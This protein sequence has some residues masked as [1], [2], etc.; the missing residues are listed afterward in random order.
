M[1]AGLDAPSHHVSSGP[2]PSSLTTLAEVLRRAGYATVAVTGGGPLGSEG[3]LF[4]GFDRYGYWVGQDDYYELIYGINRVMGWLEA[5]ADRP[6]FLFFHTF[7]VSDPFR[8]RAPYASEFGVDLQDAV[9]ESVRVEPAEPKTT[10]LQQSRQK[11]VWPDGSSYEEETLSSEQRASVVSLYDSG[12]AYAD[13]AFGQLLTR[14]RELRLEHDTLVILTS[15][16]GEALGEHGCIGHEYLSEED[17]R[18]PLVFAFPR[19]LEEPRV[20]SARARSVDILPTVIDLL[21]LPSLSG[22]DGVSLVP[23]MESDS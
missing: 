6:F 5:N 7:E 16:H 1:F 18:V 13:N 15:D 4:Q 19:R 12:I 21:G 14:L 10:G 8:A 3:G 2:A 17:L 23:L 9:E 11:L 20:I 22:I